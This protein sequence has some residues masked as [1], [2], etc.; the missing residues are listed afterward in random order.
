MNTYKLTLIAVLAA[1]AVVGRFA[2]QH[3]PNVQPVTTLIIICGFFLG[4][5]AAMILAVLTTYLSNLFLGMGIWTIWQIVA[6]ALIGLGSGLIGLWKI[7]RPLYVLVGFAV[8]SGYF[9]GLIVSLSNYI[10]TGKYFAYYLA[11]LPFDTY[12]AVGNG[13]FM[14]ILYPAL[15]VIF[16]RYNKRYVHTKIP[17]Q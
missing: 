16:K 9:Y 8:F 2:F 6:W 5:V 1:L 13:L 4:P 15:S 10:I 7:K 11:G 14:V 12:H 3:I 17:T